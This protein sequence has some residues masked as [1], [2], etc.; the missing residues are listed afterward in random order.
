MEELA[1]DAALV[2]S[3]YLSIDPGNGPRIIDAHL[4]EFWLWHGTSHEVSGTLAASGFD[5]RVANMQGL[6]GAGSYF[7][8]ALC[9]S[10][11]YAKRHTNA[12]GEHCM[13]YCR[14]VMGSPF[15]TTRGHKEER[16]PP[17]NVADPRP[18]ASFDSIFAQNRVG[19]QGHQTHNEFV[20]FRDYQVYP[21][22]I[23]RYT[24]K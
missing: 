13:L 3:W 8:D 21:E 10:H 20:V 6:Y 18:G 11:Q 4:N 12:Q 5:E 22:F 9:K 7:A 16:R 17:A 24:T 2:G 23:V 15:R 19:R 14:V 1:T